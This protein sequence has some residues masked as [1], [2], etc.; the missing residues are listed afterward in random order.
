MN[1]GEQGRSGAGRPPDEELLRRAMPGEDADNVTLSPDIPEGLLTDRE[2]LDQPE[3]KIYV[4]SLSDYNAGRL[5]GRWIDADQPVDD[6]E[7]EIQEMLAESPEPNAEEWAIHDYEGFGMLGLS[8]YES[9]EFVRHVADGIAAHGEAFAA[10][11]EFA[12]RDLDRF[13]LF[14]ALYRG[15]WESV[16][17]YARALVQGEG[18]GIQDVLAQLP[19]WVRPYASIDY[20]ALAQ[21]LQA[22][23]VTAIESTYG[24]GV[25]VFD[26]EGSP[27]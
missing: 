27:G 3:P 11:V 25:H 8:E 26:F 21:G 13:E 23:G 12:E 2:R 1:G 16:E 4:A 20:E 17:A 14:E 5:H 15:R 9:L 6:I 10:F 18:E 24:R 22:E 7:T 19:Q